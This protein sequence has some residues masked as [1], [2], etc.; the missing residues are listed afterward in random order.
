[1]RFTIIRQ[2]TYSL[3]DIRQRHSSQTVVRS[4]LVLRTLAIGIRACTLVADIRRRHFC[5]A[6]KPSEEGLSYFY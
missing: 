1:M 5:K 6:K 3:K 4:T 2:K